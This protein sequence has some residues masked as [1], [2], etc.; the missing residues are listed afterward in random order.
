MLYRLAFL[1][2]EAEVAEAR[3]GD[4]AF[5]NN[6]HPIL[7]NVIGTDNL[8]PE[9]PRQWSGHSQ[10][11]ARLAA[12]SRDV[13]PTIPFEPGTAPVSEQRTK[14]ESHLPLAVDAY[15]NLK[16][17]H[18]DNHGSQKARIRSITQ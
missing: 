11:A 4:N 9:P 2:G 3:T 6:D 17:H 1:Q 7:R 13:S 18:K 8:N 16:Q 15:E 12:R 14:V 10:T 5:D